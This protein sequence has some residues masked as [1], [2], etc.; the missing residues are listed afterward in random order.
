MLSADEFGADESLG[1]FDVAFS[2]ALREHL[3][4]GTL[5]FFASITRLGDPEF[6]ITLSAVVAVILA[7]FRRSLLAAAWIVATVVAD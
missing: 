4:H 3:S 6:L 5:R 1:R 7:A 2:A